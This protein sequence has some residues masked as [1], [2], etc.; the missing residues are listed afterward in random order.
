MKIALGSE[1]TR[2]LGAGGKPEVGKAAAI[3][4]SKEIEKALVGADMVFVTAGK[5]CTYEFR[6]LL[7]RVEMYQRS[8]PLDI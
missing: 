4:S 8:S 3:E 7:R 5:P 6:Y 2:G 1:V